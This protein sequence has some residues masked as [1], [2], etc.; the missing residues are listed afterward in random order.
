MALGIVSTKFRRRLEAVLEREGLRARFDVIVG[1]DDVTNP[2]P[3]PEA[4]LLALSMLE[5]APTEAL[6]VGDSSADGMA[7]RAAGIPFV[8]VLSGVTPLATLENLS[9]IAILGDASE[10]PALTGAG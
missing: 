9:P 7:A 3:A 6:Y 8:A 10:L 2:K 4:L 1:G 5:L